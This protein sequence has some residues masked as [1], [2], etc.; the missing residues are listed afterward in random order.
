MSEEVIFFDTLRQGLW[1]AVITSL[2]ILSVALVA[3][4]FVGL[5]QALTSIQE[6]TLTF[7]P[8]LAAI[9][10]VF[11]LTMGFMTQTLVSFF[12]DRVVPL[13]IGG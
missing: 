10:A 13:I 4:L 12:Q 3:G 11:W 6:L 5:F 1:V 8:K 7:V 2:P 9:V